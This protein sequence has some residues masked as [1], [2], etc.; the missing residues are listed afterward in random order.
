MDQLS[1]VT[2]GMQA[3]TRA[4]LIAAWEA[5]GPDKLPELLAEI[6]VLGSV[7]QPGPAP[8][9]VGAALA[10]LPQADKPAIPQEV[11]T[12]GAGVSPDTDT[13]NGGIDDMTY[14]ALNML[15]EAYKIDRNCLRAYCLKAGHLLPG[16]NGPTLAR[17]KLSEFNKLRDRLHNKKIASDNE[18]W[19]AR[20]IRVIN[21]TPTSY[22]PLPAVS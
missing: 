15:I 22:S 1:E 13:A 20:T 11:A 21:S 4:T 17:M 8:T 18:T 16:A 7:T 12:F 14:V 6:A 19:S 2:K 3:N 10:Q 9:T 5:D